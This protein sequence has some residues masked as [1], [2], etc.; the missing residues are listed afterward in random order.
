[1]VTQEIGWKSTGAVRIGAT[2][3][4]MYALTALQQ[5]LPQ[6]VTH[7]EGLI[8]Q[9]RQVRWKGE[10]VEFLGMDDIHDCAMIMAVTRTNYGRTDL[11]GFRGGR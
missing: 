6:I 7:D 10:Q 8:R 4:K 5:L 1:V 2:G 3:T 11:R 9:L